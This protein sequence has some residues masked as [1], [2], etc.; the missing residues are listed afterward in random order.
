MKAMKKRGLA[1]AGYI[2]VIIILAVLAAV[3]LPT[4][5]T[6]QED[7]RRSAVRGALKEI[8]SCIAIWHAKTLASGSTGRFPTLEELNKS[9]MPFGVPANPY[10]RSSAVAAGSSER[11]DAS[12]GWIYDAS[13]GKVYSAAP[14]TQ[15]AGF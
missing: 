4:F 12:V 2:I 7:A 14:Q 13:A 3:T 1:L 8:R 5:H 11:P 15:G 9:V 10:N 6:L